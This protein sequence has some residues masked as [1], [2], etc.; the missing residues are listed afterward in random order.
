MTQSSQKLYLLIET[1]PTLFLLREVGLKYHLRG[2]A[3]TIFYSPDLIYIG[4][5]TPSD[6]THSL[7]HLVE[8]SL[9]DEP[10]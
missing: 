4:C 8:S 10:R 2:K 6:L 9:D 3:L 5:A 1:P 7:V